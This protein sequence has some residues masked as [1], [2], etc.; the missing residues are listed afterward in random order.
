ME[1]VHEKKAVFKC[2]HYLLYTKIVSFSSSRLI[3]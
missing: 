2:K 1:D 3:T